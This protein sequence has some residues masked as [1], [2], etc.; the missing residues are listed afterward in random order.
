MPNL[1]ASAS[2]NLFR[3]V[4]RV[5]LAVGQWVVDNFTGTKA[6]NMVI[7]INQLDMDSLILDTLGFRGDLEALRAAQLAILQ[8]IETVAPI[9][10]QVIQSLIEVNQ[11][12]FMQLVP[13]MSGT[14]KG[15]LVKAVLAGVPKNKLAKS[16]QAAAG[17]TLT[18]GQVK[19]LVDTALKTFSRQVNAVMSEALP[20][21]TKYLYIGKTDEKTRDVCLA[22]LNAGPLTRKQI[23]ERFPGAF[24]D[25]GGFN[26]RHR[27]AVQTD[28]SQKFN[29]PVKA[30]AIIQ[31]KKDA[32]TYKPQTLQEQAGL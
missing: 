20:E 23:D 12:T 26:C 3:A 5:T 29:D 7:F 4:E 8:N 22:M 24:L 6:S 32:G 14:L 18:G 13:R 10:P 9:T 30:G 1:P 31:Q 21:D 27:W 19:T 2:D 25:G 17:K 11:A 15:E 16:V 28:L